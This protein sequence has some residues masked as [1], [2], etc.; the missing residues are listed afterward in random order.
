MF[1]FAGSTP[2]A[3]APVPV[4][5]PISVPA[6]APAPAPIP[7]LAPVPVPPSVG[8]STDHHRRLSR[9]SSVDR[10]LSQRRIISDFYDLRHTLGVG[11]YAS[12]RVGIERLTGAM[13]AVKI[14]DL[15]GPSSGCGH[16][17]VSNNG[18]GGAGGGSGVE[19]LVREAEL[20]RSLRHPCIVQL[21]DVFSDA[22]H[23]YL[24]KTK[25]VV[26]TTD[27]LTHP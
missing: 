25:M 15:R 13:V 27:S 5:V 10:M 16:V 17:S 11:S 6:P 21:L 20:L 22:R 23:L 24:G 26:M 14:I 7:A 1:L 3:N 18:A 8:G 2:A 4:P 12:V 19:V 9:L